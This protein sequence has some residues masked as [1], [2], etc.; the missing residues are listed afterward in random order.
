MEN[1]NA[2]YFDLTVFLKHGVLNL[3]EIADEYEQ[4]AG[5]YFGLL[6]DFY[7]TAPDVSIALA[8]F[9]GRDGNMGAYRCIDNMATLLKELKC[10]LFVAEFYSVLGSYDQGNWKLAAYLAKRITRPFD[11][12]R[13]KIASARKKKT[14]DNAPDTALPLKEYIK[15]LDEIEAGRK[16]IILAVDDSPSI[17]T[18][19]SYVLGKEYK[20]FTLPKSTELEKVLQKLTPD[21]FLL[22]YEM[23][24]LNGFELVPII[25][26]FR[27]HRDTPVIYLTSVG[28]IDTVTS[29]LAI[30]ACDFIVKPFNPDTLLE[31][32]GRHIV[33]KK[34][35]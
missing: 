16:M 14:P 23:P 1:I 11:E 5:E 19:I 10:V 18:S 13:Q 25:R 17:L 4:T 12:F 21:L 22:D 20:V 8:S 27:E 35:F 31:K 24:E 7:N 3:R 15:R 28:T 33:R 2:D 9:S 32:I 26:G 34:S 29:A 6:S 30:G